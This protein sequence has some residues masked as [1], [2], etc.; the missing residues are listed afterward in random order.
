MTLRFDPT[1]TVE[2]LQVALQQAAESAWGQDALP[3]FAPAIESTAR[4]LWR[5]CQ[6][7]LAPTDVEP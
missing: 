7:P 4:A 2:E 5:I 3:E 1:Q 6:E